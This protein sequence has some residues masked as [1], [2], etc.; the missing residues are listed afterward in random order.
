MSAVKSP[1][2]WQKP[3]LRSADKTHLYKLS[4]TL[5]FAFQ[6]SLERRPTTLLAT[7]GLPDKETLYLR[8][9]D[10]PSEPQWCNSPAA[11]GKSDDRTHH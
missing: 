7:I 4:T 8:T 5:R 3:E 10:K 2:L 6:L 9:E 11:E 1:G